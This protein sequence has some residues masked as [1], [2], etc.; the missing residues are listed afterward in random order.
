MCTARLHLWTHFASTFTGAERSLAVVLMGFYQAIWLSAVETISH[1]YRAEPNYA[2]L[3]LA[4]S[5]RE[6]LGEEQAREGAGWVWLHGYSSVHICRGSVLVGQAIPTF[7]L[8]KIMFLVR[9][10]GKIA[11]IPFSVDLFSSQFCYLGSRLGCYFDL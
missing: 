3:F 10:Q 5:Y 4:L 7:T 8:E 9:R 6:L 2:A 1:L 11:S